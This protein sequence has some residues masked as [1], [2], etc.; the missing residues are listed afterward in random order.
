VVTLRATGYL[1]TGT[2]SY[3]LLGGTAKGCRINALNRL[4]ALSP[5]TCM[6]T[7]TITATP[8][9]EGATSGVATMQFRPRPRALVLPQS[10]SLASGH[11]AFGHAVT[12]QATGYYG[13]GTVS[14]QV[15]GGTAPGCTLD[16]AHVLRATGAGTCRVTAAISAAGDYPAAVSNVATFVFAPAPIAPPPS[17]ITLSVVPF[18][19]GSTSLNTA[20]DDQIAG[21]AAVVVSKKYHVVDLTGYTDNVFTQAFNLTLDQNRAAAVQTQLETDL[22]ALHA[23]GVVV[24]VV[25][26]PTS[27]VFQPGPNVTAQ[28]RAFNRRVVATLRAS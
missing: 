1:G 16:A 4:R 21:I 18:A 22:A 15:V 7:A 27:Y 25:T 24:N 26:T 6:V 20:L 2:V 13:F 12:L 9:Y 14:Y 8:Y 10:I 19:E 28:G 3:Q 11:V 23:T 17:T 5:G